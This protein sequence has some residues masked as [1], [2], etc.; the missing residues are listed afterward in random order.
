MFLIAGESLGVLAGMVPFFIAGSVVFTWIYNR[1]RGSLLL[2]MLTHV[3]AHLNNSNKALPANVTPVVVHTV[4][5]C[6]VA[7]LLVAVDRAAFRRPYPTRAE[8]S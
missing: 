3:G 2:A 4:A 6:V 5:Y 7:L 8:A 1:T